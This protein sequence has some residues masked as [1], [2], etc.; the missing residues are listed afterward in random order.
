MTEPEKTSFARSFI[1]D[2][3]A[4]IVVFLVALPLCLGIAVASGA[5]PISG[6]IAGIVGGIVI[7]ILSGSQTSVSGPAAGLTAIVSMQI[8]Q[9]GAFDVFLAAVVLAGFIQIA[10]GIARAG[11]IADFVPGSVI[12]GLLSAIGIILILKQIPHLFGHDT[13]PEG[14]LSF[15]QPDQL[16]TFSEILVTLTGGDVHI[17]TSIIGVLSIPLLVSWDKV[18]LLKKTR[19][20]GPLVVVILGVLVSLAFDK[21]GKF[22]DIPDEHLVSVPIVKSTGQWLQDLVTPSWSALGNPAVYFAAISIA[23]VASLE[24]LLNLEAVDK[25]DPRKR[26]SPPNRE[27]VAQGVGNI[28]SGLIG[29]LPLTSVIV[30]SSVNLNAGAKSKLSAIFHGF[31]LLICVVVVPHWLNLIPL[32]VLAAILIVTGWKLASPKVIKQMWNAGWDQFLPFLVTIVAILFTDLLKGI[33]IGLIFSIL[34]ILRS[35]LQKPLR[36]YLEKYIDREVMRLDLANQVSFLNRASIRQTLNSVPVNGSLLIDAQSTEYIDADILSLIYEFVREVAPVRG[37]QVSLVGFK[38]VY[39]RPQDRVRFIDHSTA[40][41]QKSMTSDQIRSTLEQGNERFR[42]GEPI[43]RDLIESRL[44]IAS[45]NHPLAVVVSGA[46][47]RTPVEIIFDMGPGTLFCVRLTGNLPCKEVVGSVE[48]ACDTACAKLIIVMAHTNNQAVQLAIESKLNS[49]ILIPNNL[50]GILAEIQHSISE[51]DCEAW[52]TADQ[53]Q[54]AQIINGV[55]LRHAQRSARMIVEQ[56][57]TLRNLIDE[58][59]VAI[60]VAMYDIASGKV[61]F[62]G[63][64]VNQNRQPHS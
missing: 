41:I 45:R 52:I 33:I 21:L 23:L 26:V 60:S 24:T 11:F 30:R 19:I 58:G 42:I 7:G 22:W 25:L 49:R 54:Q 57:Q 44:D 12:K 20:P 13:D 43:T 10:L 51:Q 62:V 37:I 35:N 4:G 6:L 59:R 50:A 36:R 31:L 56:S 8:A 47:A 38:E 9:L 39:V 29:G 32:S 28:V 5:S 14:E 34:F 1:S 2:I 48:F 17:G 18:P 61:E 46:S 53:S 27:L 64:E 15:L 63:A 55:S 16:N 40:E 3:T